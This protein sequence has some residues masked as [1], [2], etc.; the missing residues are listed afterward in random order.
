MSDSTLEQLT[1]DILRRVEGPPGDPVRGDAARADRVVVVDVNGDRFAFNYVHLVW[2]VMQRRGVLFLHF[3]SH[4]VEVHGTRM[5]K[6]YELLMRK[7]LAVIE[8]TD[9]RHAGWGLREWEILRV[10]VRDGDV[11]PGQPWVDDKG[12]V[13]RSEGTPEGP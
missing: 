9:P 3:S 13:D 6:V 4:T 12:L 10:I 5:A 2:I 8:A 7:Q 11:E 1:A